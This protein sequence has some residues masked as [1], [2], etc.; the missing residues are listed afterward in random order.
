M[1]N[2]HLQI[3][4]K[5]INE[6][7][8]ELDDRYGNKKEAVDYCLRRLD[9]DEYSI[10]VQPTHSRILYSHEQII[11]IVE[12][13]ELRYYYSVSDNLDGIP[14]PTLNIF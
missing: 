1:R 12:A 7:I 3:A 6:V 11:H 13:L 10:V 8:N 2:E 14:T 9:K 4:S 5:L